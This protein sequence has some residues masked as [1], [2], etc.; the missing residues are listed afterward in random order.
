MPTAK[1]LRKL[2]DQRIK[3]EATARGLKSVGG[4]VYRADDVYVAVLLPIAGVDR[5]AESV[6]LTWRAEIKPLVLDEILWAAFMPDQDLGGPRKRLNLRV[7]GAFTVSGLEIGAG[8]VQAQ[9]TDDPGVVIAAMLDEFDRL[10]AEFIAAHPDVDAYLTAVR[11]CPTEQAGRPRNRLREIVTLIAVGDRDAAAALADAEVAAGEQGP[12]SGPRG[13]VFELLS[14]SCKPAEVQAEYWARTEPTH[15]LTF[16]SGTRG[17]VT[18]DRAAGRGTGGSFDRRLRAFNGHDDFALI[19]SPI[20]DEGSYLQAA[21]S[22][23]DRI[24]V[25]IRQRGGRQWG[26]ESVRYVIGRPGSDGAALDQAIELP[27]STQTVNAAEVFE[28][29]EAAELFDRYYRTGA[30]PEHYVLRPVEGWTADDAIVR[31]G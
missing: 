17:A 22:G 13:G 29:T 19:L 28:A 5:K 26:V 6:R 23:P 16:V 24:T 9:P 10:S 15:R 21:G 31:L 2:W 25:E 11:A 4:S 18:I 1:E 20:A 3:D 8:S 12:M 27:T 30:I 14:V 7:N